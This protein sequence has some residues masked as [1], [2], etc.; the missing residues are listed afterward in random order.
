ME[1]KDR[2]WKEGDRRARVG[3]GEWKKEEKTAEG[4]GEEETRRDR[5]G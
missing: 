1:D 5:R 2:N 3:R 4:N